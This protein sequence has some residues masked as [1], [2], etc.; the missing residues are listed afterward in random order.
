MFSKGGE[1]REIFAFQKRKCGCTSETTE[2]I[3]GGKCGFILQEVV[4]KT[5][6]LPLK[7]LRINRKSGIAKS[8]PEN[9]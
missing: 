7:N 9:Q 5:Y 6:S 2:L 8:D 3:N 1:A 4:D